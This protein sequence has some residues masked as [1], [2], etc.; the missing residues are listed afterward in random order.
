MN[1]LKENELT[2]DAII[3]TSTKEPI[4]K[5]GLLELLKSHRVKT[6]SI[7]NSEISMEQII[8][9]LKKANVN[10]PETFFRDL[11][12]KS[13]LS[14]LEHSKVK[15]IYK[16]EQKSKL[17]TILPYPVV[18]KYKIIPIEINN[19]YIEVAVDNPLDRRVMVTLQYLFGNWKIILHVA[20]SKTIEWAINNVY[21]EIHKQKAILDLYNRTPDQ[22]AYKVLLPK[23]KYFIISL[24]AAIG[25]CAIL[26]S[27]ITF[28]ILFA[29]IS[30]GY[31]MVNPIK[32]YI[33]LRG[34]QGSRTPTRI[35]TGEMQGV[36][37][38]DLP[39]YTVLIPVFHEAKMLAQNL[40]N[41]YHQTIPKKSWT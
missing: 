27:V 34:F 39:I 14:F 31:F 9:T 24:L 4:D 40:K 30:I 5:K 6:T 33:S 26:S 21:R 2:A 38:E 12:S 15:K 36:P 28:A 10:V 35:T 32:I 8:P 16:S 20:S 41:M 25:I 7:E 19:S 29:I 18:S 3:D 23:Q 1:I 11:A 22:S 17:I 37:D 13:G